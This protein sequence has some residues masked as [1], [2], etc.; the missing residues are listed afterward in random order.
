MEPVYNP[1]KIAE[2][3]FDEGYSCSQALLCAFAPRYGL[4]RNTALKLASPFGGGIARRGGL[5][6]AASGAI[7]VLG[8]H[9]GRTD[10]DD[11][12]TRDRNDALVCE[13]VDRYT[14]D[15]GALYCND[16]TGVDISDDTA[17]EAGKESG[18][19]EKVCPGVVRYAAQLVEELTTRP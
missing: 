9:G 6:G 15:N 7:M 8:L 19:F 14:R 10:P 1:I 17:R 18:A 11:T 4:E 2:K 5:C 13:F 16:L 3:M 12:E